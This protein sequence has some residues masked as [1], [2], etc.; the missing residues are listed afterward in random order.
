RRRAAPPPHP[1]HPPPPRPHP[2]PRL[3]RPRLPAADRAGDLGALLAGGLAAGPDRPL[4]LRPALAGRGPRAAL[5]RLLPPLPG[6]RV[7]DRPGPDPRRLGH[8]P[9][10]DPRLPDRRRRLLARLH[11][12]PRAGAR[13]RPPPPARGV[14]L[15]LR[16]GP[17]RDAADPR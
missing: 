8:P 2:G 10:P 4:H 6:G 15:R 3:L 5:R 7:G 13:R 17:R 16:A 12:R 9:R 1:P 14:D 11:P